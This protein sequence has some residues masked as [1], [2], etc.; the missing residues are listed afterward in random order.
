M[1]GQ[2]KNFH[3]FL[4]SY[5]AILVNSLVKLFDSFLYC[6]FCSSV[7]VHNMPYIVH[8]H[9]KCDKEAMMSNFRYVLISNKTRAVQK[10][11]SNFNKTGNCVSNTSCK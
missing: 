11:T 4:S 8:K 3:Q 5:F 6:I 7:H 2:L 1:S 10:P 9:Y